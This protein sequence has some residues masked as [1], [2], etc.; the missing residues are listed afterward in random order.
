VVLGGYQWSWGI[1][2]SAK[3]R[4]TTG[5]PFTPYDFGVYD[6][7]G[8]Y[9]TGYQAGIRNG[10]RMAP[11]SALDIRIEKR[12]QFPWAQLN[13]YLD[14]LNIYKGENPEFVH[15]N[16]DYTEHDYITGLP[17]IPSIGFDLEVRL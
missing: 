16:Y 3:F 2:T 15:Y 1:Y 6:I 8:D 10:D 11:Y 13:T 17:L 7:D 4:Y 14:I 5:N 9:Y 12:F